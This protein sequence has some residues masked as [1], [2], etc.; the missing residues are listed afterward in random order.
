MAETVTCPVCGQTN[1]VDMEFCQNCQSRLKPLTGPLRGEKQAILPGE[2]PT[3]KT[4]G[5][6]EAALPRWLR[7]VREQAREPGQPEPTE[8]VSQEKEEPARP[9]ADL[10]AGL[11]SQRQ[12]EDETPEWVRQIAGK[13]SKE[14]RPEPQMAKYVELHDEEE[15]APEVTAEE[16]GPAQELRSPLK[17]PEKDELGDWFREAASSTRP[18]REVPG[19]LPPTPQTMP[20]KSEESEAPSWLKGLEAQAEAER[21]QNELPLPTATPTPSEPKL[22]T[23][24]LPTWLKNLGAEPAAAE[25]PPADQPVPAWLRTTGRGEQAAASPAPEAGLPDWV[26]ALPSVESDVAAAGAAASGEDRAKPVQRE[27]GA[28]APAFNAG[29]LSSRDVDAIFASMQTPD[30]LEEATRGSGPSPE[31]M[32]PAAQEQPAIAPAELP[33]WV[34]AMRP[35]ET[36]IPAAPPAVADMPLEEGGPLAGLQGVLPVIPGAGAATSK[37]QALSVKLDATETQQTHAELL[38]KILAAEVTPVPMKSVPLVGAERGLRWAL[39]A[40]LLVVLTASVFSKSQVYPLPS[41]MPTE[42]YEALQTIDAIPEGAPV[43]VVFDY[44]PATVGEMEASAAPLIDH[45]LLMRHPALALISTSP[46]GAALAERFV[47]GTLSDRKYQ[48]GTQYVDLGYLP[49]GLAGVH[50]FAQSPIAAVPVGLDSQSVWNSPVLQGVKSLQDFSS[51]IV[52]TDSVEAGR[53]WIEQTAGLRGN[54]TMVLVTSAQAG[55]MLLPYDDAGQIN[56][57]VAG[58][59][60]AAGAEQANGGLP[61]FVRRYWDAYSTGLYIAVFLISIGGL[62]NLWRGLQERQAEET[63]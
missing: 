15:N 38:E 48:I 8:S 10:L 40:M 41:A 28:G 55:P 32:P 59:F 43:L 61:G 20:L 37:P 7:E 5:D 9:Q 22:T 1:P 12:E 45:M 63:G 33:S 30:W 57:L 36:E 3:K 47:S 2:M 29:S 44:Q 17:P 60:S 25:P 35:V 23:P 19:S 53:T 49:G 11:A 51:I 58:I 24:E 54:G 21:G 18:R 62:W 14:E 16:A 13:P 6:L 42:S 50:E 52:L 31:N 39:A 26:S 34:Q 56:G 46:T 27:P 4:T